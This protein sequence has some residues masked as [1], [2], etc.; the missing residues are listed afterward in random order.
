MTKH[1]SDCRQIGPPLRFHLSDAAGAEPASRPTTHAPQAPDLLSTDGRGGNRSRFRLTILRLGQML[2]ILQ[3][4]VG[5][6]GWGPEK[7][8]EPGIM[9]CG[10]GGLEWF[11]SKSA[12]KKRWG[13]RPVAGP[14]S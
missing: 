3:A 11:P 7:G 1:F 4:F 14:S 10:E 13:E 2:R 9:E 6:G 8:K 12:G 5:A